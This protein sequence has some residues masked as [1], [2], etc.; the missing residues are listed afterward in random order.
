MLAAGY[1]GGELITVPAAVAAHVALQRVAEAVAP[2]VDG[3]HDVV[4]ED[5][6]AVT[7]GVHGP[8]RHRGLPVGPHHSQGLQGRQRHR[9][10][11]AVLV[12]QTPPKQGP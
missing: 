4:Q 5:H 11:D 12:T 8:G 9:L 2:H 10:G 7:T 6:P 1:V 3:E